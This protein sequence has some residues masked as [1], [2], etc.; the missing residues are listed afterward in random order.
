MTNAHGHLPGSPEATRLSVK[1]HTHPERMNEIIADHLPTLLAALGT[2]SCWWLRYHSPQET[3]HLRLRIRTGCEHYAA[4]AGAAGEWRQRMRQAGMVGQ[5]A[6][7][8]A[9]PPKRWTGWPPGPLLPRLR[10]N[11]R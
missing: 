5:L 6:A 1:I 10:W 11:G 2:T 8:S 9:A 4:Y 3:D 7:S